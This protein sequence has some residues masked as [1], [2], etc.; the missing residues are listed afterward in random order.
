MKL[1]RRNWLNYFRGRDARGSPDSKWSQLA[2]RRS[3]ALPL[4]ARADR[5]GIGSRRTI[6]GDEIAETIHRTL[7]QRPISATHCGTPAFLWRRF[8]TVAFCCFPPRQFSRLARLTAGR[9]PSPTCCGSFFPL[10]HDRRLFCR[11]TQFGAPFYIPLRLGGC[12]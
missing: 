1:S 8:S 10:S 4:R 9:R 7:G 11:N 2:R 12:T 3:R 6:G 5:R